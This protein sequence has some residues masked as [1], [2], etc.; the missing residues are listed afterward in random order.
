M[1]GQL[2]EI[3]TIDYS[4][5]YYPD[6]L[7][8]L[9]QYRRDNVPEI[10][11]E[12]EYEPYVQLERAFSLVGHL[13]SVLLDVVANESLLPT[14]KLLESV[15]S[16]L[17]LIGYIMSQATPASTDVIYELSKVFTLLTEFIPQY[18]QSG[19]EET[20]DRASITY[21][22]NETNL[23]ART[24]QISYVF[25]WTAGQIEI[26][27][28][29][30]EAG[31]TITIN[32]ANFVFGTHFTAGV[33]L[34]GTAQNLADAI[35]TSLDDNISGK[36]KAIVNGAKISIINLDDST[37][38]SITE[39][40]GATD[41]FTVSDG[42]Y[43]TNFAGNAN[44]D[45][46]LFSIFANPKIG[47]CLYLAHKHIMFDKLGVTLNTVA[48]DLQGVWEYY[49]GELED[50]T[51][52]SVANL[53]SNLKVDIS[54]LFPEGI[55]CAGAIVRIKLQETS[56]FEDCISYYD[57]GKNYINTTGL[58]GQS[59]P[60]ITAGD[61]VIGS[62][63]QLL[64]ETE[65]KTENFEN[66]EDLI[67][68]L[69][70]SQTMEWQKRTVNTLYNG[71]FIR[72]R[73]VS[74]GGAPSGPEFDRL[75]IDD[76]AQYLKVAV[77]QGVQ[78]SEDPLG[79]SDGTPDQEFTLTYSPLIT[80]SL[81]IEID[82]G[83][84]FTAWSQKENFLSSNA[85]SKDYVV[86]IKADDTVIIKFGDGT[87]GKIPAAGVDNLRV[88]YRTGADIDGNVGSQ[89]ITVNK[90]G[91]SFVNRLWNPRQAQGW[92]EK[93]GSTEEDLA[94]VKIEGPASIRVLDRGITPPD[95]EYLTENYKDA[96][97]SKIISRA[98]AIEETFGI[99][100]VEDIV[101]G[102]GGSQLSVSQRQ[103]VETYFNG[104]KTIGID[105]KLVTNH[106]VTVV[107]YVRNVINVTATVYGGNKTEIENAI[108]NFIHPEA[109]YDDGVT[110]RWEFST[111]EQTQYFRKALLYAI[112]YEVDPLNITNVII[113]EPVGDIALALRE[114]PFA[115]I[116]NVT[117]I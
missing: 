60:S 9:V 38:I 20:E 35:N 109:K 13:N 53:G 66:A 96:A 101:V 76:G 7:K 75:R 105:G 78:R 31:D 70:E 97:G 107:N 90:S 88:T 19:T 86:D 43:S 45:A 15:R 12:N 36:I 44:T 14:A 103:D 67:F 16:H 61:Y 111:A 110:P 23:M 93:E 30:L 32:T 81:V 112:I 33:D 17:K 3:P 115:G 58:L 42:V 77:T 4:Q 2:I 8:M 72:Y 27:N 113:S 98:K 74:L 92:T 104:D 63:W 59:S 84:G 83:T 80:G 11:D 106:E 94:R 28:N 51:P 1:P 26:I 116:V 52:E 73:I 54:T 49:D 102:T 39:S 71:H 69:P 41:N 50:E 64:P 46:S 18:T 117:I 24:D 82:E 34:A 65:D 47:D 56:A 89:T 21:E 95:I 40:D 55:N 108:K 114:L 10:T 85:N 22:A 5:M 87:R 6:I 37:P 48:V 79:S 100:T 29:S 57:A 99:K 62:L 91:I 68:Q 25:D